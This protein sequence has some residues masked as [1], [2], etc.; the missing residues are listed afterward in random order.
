[1]RPARFIVL[2][3]LLLALAACDTAEPPPHLRVAGGDPAIG[4]ELIGATGCGA[5]HV[6]P[7]I[8]QARGRMAPPLTDFAG[9]TV[10]AGTLPNTAGNLVLWI[11]D[12]PALQPGTAMPVPGVSIEEARHIAAY[13]STLGAGKVRREAAGPPLASVREGAARELADEGRRSLE[14]A[15]IVDAAAGV[16]RVPIDDAMALVAAGLRPST[17]PPMPLME[18]QQGVIR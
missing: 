4:R 12:P 8:T 14:A 18:P 13:L 9:R 2:P 6:V 17:A 3:A 10:I 15:S 5:C 11:V 1:M 7:G 16:A